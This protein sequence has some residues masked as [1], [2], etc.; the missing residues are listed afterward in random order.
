MLIDKFPRRRYFVLDTCPSVFEHVVRYLRGYDV[1]MEMAQRVQKDLTKDAEFYGLHGLVNLLS[2]D[3]AHQGWAIGN[4]FS[5]SEQEERDSESTVPTVRDDNAPMFMD[6]EVSP[7]TQPLDECRFTFNPFV[8]YVN[9]QP[10]Q[11]SY[12]NDAELEQ[13]AEQIVNQ[14]IETAETECN[15]VNSGDIDLRFRTGYD[16]EATHYDDMNTISTLDCS[17]PCNL[18]DTDAIEWTLFDNYLP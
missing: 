18:S 7:S 2:S 6:D 13:F 3:C 8:D 17:R 11:S 10:Q 15:Q 1:D 14:A 9:S 12:M 5:A 16:Y 4:L